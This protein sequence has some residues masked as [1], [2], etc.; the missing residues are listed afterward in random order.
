MSDNHT[1]LRFSP[2]AAPDRFV[3]AEK[4]AAQKLNDALQSVVNTAFLIASAPPV[5]RNVST[6]VVERR[7]ESH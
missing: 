6:L 5:P 1:T 7:G 4:L 3:K 2:I